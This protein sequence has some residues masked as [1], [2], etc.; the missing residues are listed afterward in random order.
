MRT[1]FADKVFMLPDKLPSFMPRPMQ[2]QGFHPKTV[3]VR[4]N[5]G[6]AVSGASAVR[7]SVVRLAL[8]MPELESQNL[9]PAL[10]IKAD[11]EEMESEELVILSLRIVVSLDVT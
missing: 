3:I 5:S 4:M 7:G 9:L 11:P 8:G 6:G 10:G 1:C 2:I